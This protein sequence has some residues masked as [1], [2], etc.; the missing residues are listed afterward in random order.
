MMVNGARLVPDPS[1]ALWWPGEKTLVVADLHFEKGSS[2]ATRGRNFL[3]PYDTR[4]TV[5]AL[6]RLVRHYTPKRLVA[7]GDSFHDDGAASRLHIDDVARLERIAEQTELVWIA[8]N[9]DPSPP[10]GLGGRIEEELAIGPLRFRHI[11]EGREAGEVA[12]HLHPK[13]TVVVRG[14]GL[15]RRCFVTDGVKLV[16]PAFGAYAGGLD[17]RDQAFFTLFRRRFTAWML[18]DARVFPVPAARLGFAESEATA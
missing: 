17:V 2:F 5:E 10:D 14:H 8:G 15:T 11:P 6:A 13:A 7:L 18:G 16:L 3:P 4:A 1:G 9:H 12:G